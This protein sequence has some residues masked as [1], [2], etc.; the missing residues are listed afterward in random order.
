M[1]TNLCGLMI[2]AAFLTVQPPTPQVPEGSKTID[3]ACLVA[4]MS[5]KSMSDPRPDA[6]KDDMEETRNTSFVVS[7][8]YMGRLTALYPHQNWLK[9]ATDPVNRPNTDEALK[10]SFVCI[11]RAALLALGDDHPSS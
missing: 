11:G 2:T 8:F 10:M 7:Q 1:F 5:M 4:T 6:N 3:A 9:F